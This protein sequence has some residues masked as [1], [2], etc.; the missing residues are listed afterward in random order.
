MAGYPPSISF[1][2]GM[3]LPML[4]GLVRNARLTRQLAKISH[5]RN[6]LQSFARA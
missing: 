2:K 4:T 6:V 5:R 1:S 3:I